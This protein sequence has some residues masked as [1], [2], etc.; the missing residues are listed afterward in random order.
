MLTLRHS[1]L[2]LVVVVMLTFISGT[3]YA[4]RSYTWYKIGTHT[5]KF[6]MV[7]LSTAPQKITIETKHLTPISLGPSGKFYDWSKIYFS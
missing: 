3:A 2:T 4:Q 5:F 7:D 6:W 1:F